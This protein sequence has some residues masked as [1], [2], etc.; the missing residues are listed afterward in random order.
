MFPQVLG[1]GTQQGDS[2]DGSPDAY[3]EDTPQWD[4]RVGVKSTVG[5]DY[6]TSSDQSHV[7]GQAL[8]PAGSFSVSIWVKAESLTS[9]GTIMGCFESGTSSNRAWAVY[10]R[11]STGHFQFRVSRVGDGTDQA[12]AESA[13]AITTGVLYHIVGTFDASTGTATIY[14]NA[15]N[16]ATDTMVTPGACYQSS[17]IAFRV[18]DD[19]G[20]AA[21]WDG[22]I[23]RA[24]VFDGTVLTSGQVTT[25]YNSGTPLSYADLPDAIQ[26]LCDYAWDLDEASGSALEC[27]G[28]TGSW[29]LT[30]TNAPV[31]AIGAI[32]A[33]TCTASSASNGPAITTAEEQGSQGLHLTQ[34][35]LPACPQY[36][37]DPDDSLPAVYFDGSDDYLAITTDTVASGSLGAVFASVRPAGM[38]VIWGVGENVASGGNLYGGTVAQ[39]TREAVVAHKVSSSGDA[40]TLY[41]DSVVALDTWQTFAWISSG[42]AYTVRLDGVVQ[43]LAVSF[44]SPVTDGNSGDWVAEITTPTRF[45]IGGLLRN[46]LAAPSELYLRQLFVLDIEPT[47]DQAAASETYLGTYS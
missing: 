16:S 43:T 36:R 40:E 42:S 29:D 31:G 19:P 4:A 14:V 8:L 32:T 13:L 39:V 34:T 37:L 6:E 11:S 3:G 22:L 30:A 17:T 41:G 38:G 44:D 10:Y 23:G 35:S 26:S 46:V 25:L 24:Q 2:F 18:G 15:A 47:A 5:R 1:F 27:S 7:A 21:P 45:A 28:A 9:S 12:D 20:T 33:T